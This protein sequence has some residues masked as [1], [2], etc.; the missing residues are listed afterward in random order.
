MSLNVWY[1]INSDRL[2]AF[3][4]IMATNAKM[5]NLKKRI[6]DKFHLIYAHTYVNKGMDIPLYL[7]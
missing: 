7:L 2:L 3:T 4:C 6:V 1:I 5:D